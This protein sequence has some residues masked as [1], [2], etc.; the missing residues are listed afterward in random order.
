MSGSTSKNNL[1]SA[2]STTVPRTKHMLTAAQVQVTEGVVNAME[3]QKLD[4]MV[5][6]TA[7]DPFTTM[8][9]VW[10]S[11]YHRADRLLSGEHDCKK[12][13]GDLIGVAPNKP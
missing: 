13:R 5:A 4:L 6:L 8:L 1:R 12:G 3:K 9:L 7:A 2:S 10:D 11:R